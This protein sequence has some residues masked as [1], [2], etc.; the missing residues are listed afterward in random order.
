MLAGVAGLVSAGAI[1]LAYFAYYPR[2][3]V[4]S[5]SVATDPAQPFSEPFM[6]TNIGSVP[7]YSVK[8]VCSDPTGIDFRFMTGPPD[9]LEPGEH[10]SFEEF[11]KVSAFSITKLRPSERHPFTCFGFKP[12]SFSSSMG[13]S[14]VM[15]HAWVNIKVSFELF[16]LPKTFSDEFPF[17]GYLHEDGTVHWSETPLQESPPSTPPK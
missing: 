16:F 10:M 6:L 12:I 13:R 15:N 4:D 2:V 1:A 17:D 11:A 14:V 7:I 8:V 3:S 9:K 5:P